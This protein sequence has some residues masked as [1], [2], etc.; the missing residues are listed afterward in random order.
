MPNNDLDSVGG[1]PARVSEI[2]VGKQW[3]PCF[4]D[5]DEPVLYL[6][7]FESG[8]EDAERIC[9]I[10][11]RVYQLG[12]GIDMAW[13][14]SRVLDPSEAAACLES[15]PG[16][17][18]RC[19]G[20]GETAIPSPG[21]LDS[22]VERYQRKRSRLKMVGTGRKSRQLFTQ[23]P[24]ASFGRKGYDAPPRR[25]HFELRR[26]EGGFAPRPLAS[27]APLVI[28]LRD[29][30][31]ARLQESL[32]ENSALFERLIIGRGAGPA[33]LAQRIRLISHS[34]DRSAA[35]GPLHPARRRRNPP[36]LPDPSRRS[37]VGVCRASA[38]QPV[39]RRDLAGKP[40]ID[41]RLQDGGSVPGDRHACSEA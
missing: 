32:S 28:G 40:G 26:E 37:E 2:R 22:L 34:L 23:P 12:R 25:L 36:G 35:Y 8:P 38:L 14:C 30:A 16:V 20:A 11:E 10:A 13:A 9:A 24:K 41:G 15:H 4:F 21:T 31:A 18:R 29:G 19:A 5:S 3:R 33:A 17:V 6:W 1:D 27:V 39:L 7:D